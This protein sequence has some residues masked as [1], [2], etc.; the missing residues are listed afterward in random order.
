MDEYLRSDERVRE[1]R[2][3]KAVLYAHR[4]RR[5]DGGRR[6]SS[7]E[8]DLSDLSDEDAAGVRPAMSMFCPFPLILLCLSSFLCFGELS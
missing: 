5:G 1:V 2:E 8:E 7:Y 6:G 3:W 4:R